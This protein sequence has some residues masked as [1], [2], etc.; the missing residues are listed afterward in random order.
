MEQAGKLLLDRIRMYQEGNSDGIYD[1]YHSESDFKKFFNTKEVYSEHFS[2]L[3][4]SGVP[5]SIEFYKILYNN[6]SVEV[7]YL[8]VVFDKEN[9]D[10][11]KYYTKTILKEEQGSLKIVREIRE[12]C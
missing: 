1:L 3:I 5:E 9:G 8:E 4:L 10:Y 6:D 7:L 11:K 2:K 12:S